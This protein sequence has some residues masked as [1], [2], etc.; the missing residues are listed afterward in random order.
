MKKFIL[1]FSYLF[2][3]L[4]VG[5]YGTLFF[6]LLESKW[7]QTQ[8]IYFYLIQVVILTV[9]VPVTAF[10]LLVSL[11]KLSSFQIA[12]VA[13]RRTPLLINCVLFYILIKYSVTIQ[14]MPPLFF[15]F[16]GAIISSVICFVALFLRIK[17]S[18]HMVGITSLTLFVVSLSLHLHV[19]LIATIALLILS[20]GFVATSRIIMKAHNLQE[21]IYGFIVGLISQIGLWNLWLF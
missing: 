7:F 4:F 15:Y 12:S 9:L 18:L 21:I 1:L 5:L 19:N 17:V 14:S 11:G 2:H 20:I 6:F 3:P 13:E 8:E 10:Y 16:L